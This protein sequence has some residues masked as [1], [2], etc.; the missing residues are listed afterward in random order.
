MLLRS[1]TCSSASL[2]LSIYL[3]SVEKGKRGMLLGFSFPLRVCVYVSFSLSFSIIDTCL[4]KRAL[5]CSEYTW[6]DKVH[7]LCF[8]NL[9][10]HTGRAVAGSG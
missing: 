10:G 2:P 9:I 5:A 4:L 8:S 6:Q 1:Y 7:I 3:S